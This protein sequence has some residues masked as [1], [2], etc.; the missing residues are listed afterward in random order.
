MNTVRNVSRNSYLVYYLVC[1]VG[2]FT[3]LNYQSIHHRTISSVVGNANNT[4]AVLPKSNKSNESNSKITRKSLRIG[5]CK[6][7]S[8]STQCQIGFNIIE[9]YE[10]N[11][12]LNNVGCCFICKEKTYISAS[13]IIFYSE[14]VSSAYGWYWHMQE[15]LLHDIQASKDLLF[16]GPVY[17][18]T[19]DNATLSYSS[20]FELHQA[21]LPFLS[22]SHVMNCSST[23]NLFIY[24]PDFHFIQ[25][26]GYKSLI[27]NINLRDLSFHDKEKKV[28]WRGSTT[29]IFSPNSLVRSCYNL[30]RIKL[31]LKSSRIDWI[32]AQ[33]TN[34]I[35]YCKIPE[36]IGND[37]LTIF[38]KVDEINWIKYRGI[39]DI[40]GNTNAWGLFWRLASGSVVFKVQSDFTNAYTQKLKPWIHYVPISKDLDDL[41]DNT[42]LVTDDEYIP[43]LEKISA[44]A[45]K[46][47]KLFTYEREIQRVV[48]ELNQYIYH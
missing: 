39:L 31:A 9:K 45:K 11:E 6:T 13:K 38:P 43:L 32:D 19:E 27:D 34:F 40:D 16:S 44:N 3:V 17:F 20:E 33:I 46:I 30:P 26:R 21:R 23:V 37:S 18:I 2:L 28:F 41:E 1:S 15:I 35:H 10:N 42:R 22:H 4:Y 12:K 36:F 24:Q 8:A 47:T 29:G 7:A 25:H 14:N 48:K 5:C